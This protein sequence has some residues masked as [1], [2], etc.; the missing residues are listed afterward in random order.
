MVTPELRCPTMPFT[1][2]STN[3]CA[4]VV[5]TLGSAWSSSATSANFTVFPSILIPAPFA[6]STARRAPFSLSL[7]KWAIPPVSGPTWPIFTSSALGCA[8]ACGA[9]VPDCA[10]AGGFCCPQAA[11]AS[12]A[13]RVR[14]SLEFFMASSG[15]ETGAVSYPAAAS[16]LRKN[17]AH[18]GLD[19]GVGH[20][21]IGRHGHLTPYALAAFLDLFEELRR[22]VGIA[23]VFGRN[24]LVRRTD[25][26]LVD[27]VAGEAVVLLGELLVGMRGQRERYPRH[28]E[29]DGDDFHGF[30]L[31][32]CFS[33]VRSLIGSRQLTPRHSHPL[34]GSGRA[35]LAST[36]GTLATPSAMASTLV[37]ARYSRAQSPLQPEKSRSRPRK[38]STAVGSS[39][40]QSAIAMVAKPATCSR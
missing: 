28:A 37:P 20:L 22:R 7:P 15:V 12:A 29:E 16:L 5:P 36:A 11:S 24:V 39:C 18:Q 38:T 14:A 32:A 10:L 17:P 1:L 19:V 33:C 30:S 13:T 35:G 8:A 26:L 40:S 3:F 34:T 21:H 27:G 4:T 2:A 23:A 31:Q 6:S 25:E 9:A